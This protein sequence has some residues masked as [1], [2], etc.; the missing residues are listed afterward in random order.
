M[1]GQLGAR[2]VAILYLAAHLYQFLSSPCSFWTVLIYHV[3]CC[4][5]GVF[6]LFPWSFFESRNPSPFH[7]F[8]DYLYDSS[9]FPA[10]SL[11]LY[12]YLSLCVCL[13]QCLCLYSML[14]LFSLLQ[15]DLKSFQHGLFFLTSMFVTH[16]DCCDAFSLPSGYCSCYSSIFYPLFVLCPCL[17][18]SPGLLPPSFFSFFFSPLF[19]QDF[20]FYSL[21][22][23]CPAHSLR[24]CISYCFA[25]H[26]M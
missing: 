11:F 23:R 14:R 25:L 2:L 24:T 26:E 17:C 6:L 18:I 21:T 4:L 5:N 1:E 13:Y 22:G 7:L 3:L 12:I 16:P 15:N 20:Y 10:P 19:L 9:L 8:S